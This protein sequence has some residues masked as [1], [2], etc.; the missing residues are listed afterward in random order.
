MGRWWCV[1]AAAGIVAGC[2]DGGR[3]G[4][5]APVDAR[6]GGG[7]AR[8]DLEAHDG[9]PV[10]AWADPRDARPP[11]PDGP[12]VGPMDAAL[13]PSDRAA[14]PADVVLPTFDA[15]APV[16]DAVAARDA[17]GGSTPDA[18]GG[19]T[20]DAVAVAVSDAAAPAPDAIVP[21]PDAAVPPADGAPPVA[22]SR[23]DVREPDAA[24]I[25]EDCAIWTGDAAADGGGDGGPV[26][27]P[28]WCGDGVLDLALGEACDDGAV[29]GSDGACLGNCSGW[30]LCPGDAEK[31]SPGIC[32]CGVPDLDTDGDGL[33]DCHDACAGDAQKTV[34]GA[35]GCGVPDLDT[36]GDSVADCLDACADDPRKIVPGL[37]GCGVPDLDTDGDG[38]LDCEDPCPLDAAKR[39][40]GVC[41]CGVP[42]LDTDG[43]GVL[44]CEDPCPL[45]AAKG[46]PGQCGCGV[47]DL[48]TDGDGAA[49]CV[50]ACPNDPR[51]A[52]VGACGCFFD[53]LDSDADGVA[54]CVDTSPYPTI[55]GAPA[56]SATWEPSGLAV[57]GARAWV[58]N[59]K[60]GVV[61]GYPLPLHDGVNVPD[62]SFAV[63]PNGVTPKWEA[64]RVDAAGNLLLLNAN[65]R[66]V[67]RC[68]PALSCANPQLVPLPAAVAGLGAVR[69]EALAVAGP[70]IWLGS[71]TTPSRMADDLGNV[72]NLGNP[73]LGGHTY[74]LSDLVES[75][76]RF[77]LA[78]SYENAAGTTTADVAG[79]VAVLDEDAQG[80]PVLASLR[81][82]RTLA[83]KAEGLD[84]DGTD[85][86]VTFDE[87]ASRKGIGV[88]TKFQ[89]TTPQEFAT[90]VPLA[91]C[92]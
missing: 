55:L 30:D 1:C 31:V 48:D 88:A 79:L 91:V 32:G 63:R 62:V 86:I 81:V 25:P 29:N 77:Y 47:P 72:V 24:P 82:C 10:D 49:N 68:D 46:A 3:G 87:D 28:G 14:P 58:A 18:A 74:Q 13:P 66:S 70:R 34:P 26:C 35:C 12:A 42:D 23:P 90:R 64:L 80:R 76:G 27:E 37:C 19:V 21:P 67:W 39:A 38:A 60:D 41:G 33:A 17:A 50:D 20:P 40:P 53:D 15:L 8:A 2:G 22:D 83:G 71:R 73:S 65:D 75:G 54:D 84:V 59:D 69:Y 92:P 57:L 61:A 4:D 36:D 56:G 6:S 89:L 78:W 16:E 9:S 51:K 52:G 85:L 44:D 7:D 43:D 5:R 45:D 11:A